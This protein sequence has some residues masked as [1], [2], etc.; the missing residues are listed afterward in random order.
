[1]T[2]MPLTAYFTLSQQPRVEFSSAGFADATVSA[3]LTGYWIQ[4]S[5]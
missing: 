5:P 1:M 3:T 4:T 2:V